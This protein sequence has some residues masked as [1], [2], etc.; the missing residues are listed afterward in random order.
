MG[1]KVEASSSLSS[2][3]KTEEPLP[4][5]KPLTA[6]EMWKK[7]GGKG[8]F[9]KADVAVREKYSS[10]YTTF[11]A[12]YS[13]AVAAYVDWL[14]TGGGGRNVVEEASGC[15]FVGPKKEK[16]EVRS[17]VRRFARK[18]STSFLANA[19]VTFPDEAQSEAR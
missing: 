11:S 1:I 8:A 14:H 18:G 6:A 16:K 19:S 3:V 5:V 17:G 12:Q 9:G 4:P 15:S 13:A 7:A 2:Q 10:Q